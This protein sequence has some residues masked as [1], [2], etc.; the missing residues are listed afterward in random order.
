MIYKKTKSRI[1]KLIFGGFGIVAIS[2]LL[3]MFVKLNTNIYAVAQ[4]VMLAGFVLL[5]LA[6]ILVLKYGKKKK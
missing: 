6:L 3:F 1:T 5:L 4:T 2:Q